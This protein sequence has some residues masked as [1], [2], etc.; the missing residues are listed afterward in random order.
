MGRYLR[1]VLRHTMGYD[2]RDARGRRSETVARREQPAARVAELADALDLGSSGLWPWGFES[3]P[4]QFRPWCSQPAGEAA[5]QTG[6]PLC[7]PTRRPPQRRPAVPAG[8]PD[9]SIGAF[10]GS[11]DNI[12]LP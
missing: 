10:A 6:R 9:R 12:F 7:S 1:G 11:A 4:S 3:P 5:W 8:T 2:A